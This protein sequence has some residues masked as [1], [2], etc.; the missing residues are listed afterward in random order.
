MINF[1]TPSVAEKAMQHF[2]GFAFG[3]QCLGAAW[4]T[5]RQ[6]LDALIWRYRSSAVMNRNVAETHK[7]VLFEHGIRIRLPIPTGDWNLC[8]NFDK[9]CPAPVKGES[10]QSLH[11]LKVVQHKLISKTPP[12]I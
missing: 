3:E 9:E 5:R 7:P 4:S 1:V 11:I 10:N 6:G 8:A 2:D 12:G